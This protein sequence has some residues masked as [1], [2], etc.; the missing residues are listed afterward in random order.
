[1]KLA[2]ESVFKQLPA[3][4]RDL[5][6]HHLATD[7]FI[8]LLEASIQQLIGLYSNIDETKTAE[9]IKQELHE[10]RTE[11]LFLASLLSLLKKAKKAS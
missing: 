11:H 6:L 10:I 8:E 5:L 9:E 3:A 1:M 4:Y 7:G 2:P